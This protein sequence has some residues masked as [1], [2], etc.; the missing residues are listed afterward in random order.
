MIWTNDRRSVLFFLRFDRVVLLHFFIVFVSS[1]ALGLLFLHSSLTFWRLQVGKGMLI[2]HQTHDH[3]EFEPAVISRNLPQIIFSFFRTGS[4]QRA[5]VVSIKTVLI[6]FVA[7]QFVF[8]YS[9]T[10]SYIQLLQSSS[11]R[12]LTL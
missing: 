3:R 1:F 7:Y 9:K 4:V 11:I 12:N 5:I 8:G 10:N 6:Y 2:L